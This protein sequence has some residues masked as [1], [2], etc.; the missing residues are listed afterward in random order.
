[1]KVRDLLEAPFDDA[2]EKEFLDNTPL[3]SMNK[4]TSKYRVRDVDPDAEEVGEDD[5]VKTAY[6]RVYVKPD[7]KWA[8]K[9]FH[10]DPKTVAYLKWAKEHQDNPYVPKIKTLKVEKDKDGETAYV[11][12]EKLEPIDKNF[13]W[14]EHHIPFLLYA[15]ALQLDH[16][17]NFYFSKAMGVEHDP[18]SR[19]RHELF[20]NL[21]AYDFWKKENMKKAEADQHLVDAFNEA[22]DIAQGP[23]DISFWSNGK[24]HNIMRRPGTDELVITDPIA[25]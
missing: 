23:L 8:V 19:Q 9:I 2:Q 18:S 12:F 24:V 16:V 14:K 3:R 4:S 17:P 15:D 22:S 6:G 11:R 5:P 13:P 21:R 1:M 25:S 7:S 20:D 10:N